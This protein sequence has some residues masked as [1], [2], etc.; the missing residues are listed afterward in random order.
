METMLSSNETENFS[1]I[2]DSLFYPTYN[3][4]KSSYV[5]TSGTDFYMSGFAIKFQEG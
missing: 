4:N 5:T 1:D 3:L 2:F